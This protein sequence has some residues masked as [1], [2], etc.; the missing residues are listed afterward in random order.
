MIRMYSIYPCLTS[1][2]NFMCPGINSMQN[3]M[4]AVGAAGCHTS[5]FD[6]K[7]HLDDVYEISIPHSNFI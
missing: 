1:I 6:F 5:R 7:S 4:G 2:D 3:T